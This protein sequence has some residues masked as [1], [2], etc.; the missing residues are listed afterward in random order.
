MKTLSHFHYHAGF[1]TKQQK[2]VRVFEQDSRPSQGKTRRAYNRDILGGVR[3]EYNS[4]FRLSSPLL[5]NNQNTA[6][7]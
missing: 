5:Q 2:P 1:A 6:P 4:L 7:R 3:G